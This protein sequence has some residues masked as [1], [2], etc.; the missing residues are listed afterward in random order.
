MNENKTLKSL[1]PFFDPNELPEFPFIF[2][3]AP[4]RSGKTTLIKNLV[5][6]YFW[7]KYDFIVAIC[8]NYHCAREYTKSG[9]VVEKYCHGSYNHEILQKWF[10]KSDKL[11]KQGK[12]LPKTL[13]ILDDVLT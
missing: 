10:E 5:L 12:E 3:V 6:N 7:N 13:F 8:G 4:R 2:L 11:L 9:A 1:L